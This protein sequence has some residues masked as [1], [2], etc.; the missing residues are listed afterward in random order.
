MDAL[1]ELR[2][3]YSANNKTLY[4]NKAL[5]CGPGQFCAGREI[6]FRYLGITDR[7]YE[8]IIQH[9][10]SFDMLL[11]NFKASYFAVALLMPEE[12]FTGRCEAYRNA[13]QMARESLAGPLY[14][15]W[16]NSGND[17]AAP[18]KRPAPPFQHRSSLLSS[19]GRQRR[20]RRVWDHKGTPSIPTP[21]SLRQCNAWT[22]LPALG[23]DQLYETPRRSGCQEK[24]QA[25][26]CGGTDIPVL[27]D[28]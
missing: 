25:A 27:A 28:A 21:Q 19:P 13:A 17:D 9:S 22:L 2:S 11:N 20:Q 3:Y 16:C 1:R 14:K 7:P 4:I 5:Q 15:I 18:Y 24:I 10:D 26:R 6:A 8:T 23:I 12:N